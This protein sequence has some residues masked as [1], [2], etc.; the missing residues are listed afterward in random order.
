MP[1]LAKQGHSVILQLAKI[2]YVRQ[3][4]VIDYS[5]YVRSE[6]TD[7]EDGPGR[8]FRGGNPPRREFRLV[9]LLRFDVRLMQIDGRAPQP[10]A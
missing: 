6:K 4:T 1:Q 10:R 8:G 5:I 7:D 2:H 3:Y 9:Y